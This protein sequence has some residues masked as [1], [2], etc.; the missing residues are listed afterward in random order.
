MHILHSMSSGNRSSRLSFGLF[1]ADL[2]SGQLSK[3]G[4]PI[5]L[6]N[7][8]FQVLAVLLEHQGEIVTRE[9]LRALLWPDGT[10]GDFDDRLNTAVKKLRH[11]L[12]DAAETPV[13]I[14][15]VP[16]RGYRFIPPI[17]AM[18]AELGAPVNSDTSA[19]PVPIGEDAAGRLATQ[20]FSESVARNLNHTTLKHLSLICGAV[21]LVIVAAVG[22]RSRPSRIGNVN[23]QKMD[24][25][26][27]TDRGDVHRVAISPNGRYI[28]YAAFTGKGSSIRV[29]QVDTGSD[30]E[31][32]PPSASKLIGLTFSPDGNYIYFVE[33]VKGAAGQNHL[34]VIPMLGG[35][36][37]L[38][39]R[40]VDSIIGFSPEGSNFTF[41]RG[42]GDRNLLEV[43]SASAD[44]RD[45]RLIA[46]I[47]DGYDDF[48]NGPTWSP[49]GRLIAVPVM[50]RGKHELRWALDIISVTSG[51][52][53]EL[54]S[55]SAGIGRAVWLPD[56]HALLVTLLDQAG[57]GQL[58]AI[59]YPGGQAIRLTNDIEDYQ[60]DL[61]VAWSG[62]SLAV[63]AR[64]RASNIWVADATTS[65]ARQITTD[66]I[67]LTEIAPLPAGMLLAQSTVGGMS[68]MN[69]DGSERIPFGIERNA[70]FSTSCGRFVVFD[71]IHD[72]SVHLI[73]VDSDGLNP[74]KLFTGN[75]G[76][77]TCTPDGK[78]VFVV[79][80]VKPYT[81]LRIS[82]EGGNPL[83]IAKSPG[84]D[85]LG[86]LA[87]SPDGEFL[88]FA[89]DEVSAPL[90]SKLAI[91]RAAG[92][93]PVKTYPVS[94]EIS[95]LRWSPDGQKLQYLLTR[96]GA[97]NVWEQ[98]LAGGQPRQFT[99]FISGE[100][101]DFSWSADG[102]QLLLARGKTTGDI[103]LVKNFR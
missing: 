85:I 86:P 90:G 66:S 72:R 47:P 69:A 24:I 98:P 23:P 83:E 14:E 29:G 27:W 68:R 96:D 31:V 44:G 79:L 30:V 2:S 37:R 35:Q 21:A 75:I 92:G 8:P 39:L 50:I 91:I 76:P 5:R 18:Q 34:Y 28:A 11:A 103:L 78:Y 48:Q 41:T 101:F 59:S 64:S 20:S 36:A 51:T 61:D 89:F 1:E 74:R 16:R 82:L 88:A 42:L 87:I 7:Q 10:Y 15:T 6:E 100:V 46:S 94:E 67:A 77:P 33:A 43:R 81:I 95:G 93:A 25:T 52:V 26:R 84:Y 58:W 80:A 71:S 63:I 70:H 65:N 57:R 54:Y 62:M 13:F 102:K 17:T 60:Y 4:Q 38:L 40:D 22:M 32:W 9:Q 55:S 45:E 56:N 12:G 53:R 73:R 97:T 49:D 3:R 19:N 99:N